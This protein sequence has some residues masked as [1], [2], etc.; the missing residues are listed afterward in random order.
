MWPAMLLGVSALTTCLPM[1]RNNREQREDFHY[2]QGPPQ[3]LCCGGTE[4]HPAILTGD[5][6]GS[7]VI[8]NDSGSGFNK[9]G[10]EFPFHHRWHLNIKGRIFT[11]TAQAVTALEPGLWKQQKELLSYSTCVWMKGGNTHTYT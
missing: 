2:A 8:R 7:A 4:I 1:V 10:L 5:E 6:S 9:T 3:S 11:T